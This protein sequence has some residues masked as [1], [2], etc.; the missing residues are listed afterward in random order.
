[1]IPTLS[2]IINK[3][4]TPSTLS[5]CALS[6]VKPSSSVALCGNLLDVF[7]FIFA[8]VLFPLTFISA[9]TAAAWCH[10]DGVSSGVILA[11]VT[12]SS[13]LVVAISER[14]LPAYPEWNQS[15]EDVPTDMMHALISMILLPKALEILI[16]IGIFYLASHQIGVAFDHWP[17]SF[18]LLAQLVLAM[19]ISQFF[20][21]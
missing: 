5:K 12:L 15:K 18:P 3:K 10:A 1:M 9:L 6:T 11:T 13:A 17:S 2:T 19:V 4:T 14:I 20:E 16:V 21:Y 8:R 7:S